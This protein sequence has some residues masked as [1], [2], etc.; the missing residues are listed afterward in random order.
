MT[1]TAGAGGLVVVAD[2]IGGL[3]MCGRSLRR[4]VPR[5]GLPHEV[6]VW[7]WGHGFGRWL[8]DL[9]DSENHRRMSR[10]L[11]DRV[12]RFR[13]RRPEGPV[14]LV[15]KSGGTGLV[16]WA[17]EALPEGAVDRAILLAPALSPGY[18][19]SRALRGVTRDVVAFVSPLDLVL[20]GL[21]T[22]LFGTVDRVRGPGAGLLGFRPPEGADPAAAGLYRDRLRQVRW[23]P[24]MVGVGYLGGHFAVD[25]PP[26][27][28]R[29]VLPLLG[30][31]PGPDRGLPST[32][33]AA[34]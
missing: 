28:A 3:D 30:P 7:R 19:L 14:Y 29:Y 20:L 15:G 23:T 25:W 24:A 4:L 17:L 9:T 34:G 26:F 5:A 8:A 33:P 22:G 21:G 6:E 10:A 13:D 16:V 32:G 2:G 27:L 31:E 1:A 12:A 18:D 11:A